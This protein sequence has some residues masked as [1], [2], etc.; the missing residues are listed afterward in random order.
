[1]TEAQRKTYLKYGAIALAAI[2][3]L[4]WAVIS[5]A[6]GLWSSQADS[7][8][9]LNKKIQRGQQL[10]DRQDTIRN[11]WDQMLKANLPSE[12]SAAESEAFQ[13]IERWSSPAGISFANLTPTWDNTNPGYE[14]FEFRASATGTQA[15]LARFIYELE[16]DPIPVNLDELEFTT[17]DDRG[18]I[19]TMT[20]RFS[21]LR[22]DPS[23]KGSR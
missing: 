1:M 15:S 21:F 2:W 16:T 10:I 4:D 22:I 14:T 12:V 7:I 23:S 9:S 20:A 6:M 3:F 19:L 11:R 8:D 17:R 5:P 13:A 18:A